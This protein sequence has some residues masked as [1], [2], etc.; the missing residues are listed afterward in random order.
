MR[1]DGHWVECPCPPGYDHKYMPHSEAVRSCVELQAAIAKA[2]RL[3]VGH[4]TV[5]HCGCRKVKEKK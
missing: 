3:P 2:K 1:E 4:I 5:P